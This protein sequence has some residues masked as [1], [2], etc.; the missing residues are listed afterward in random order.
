MPGAHIIFPKR[1]QY[2]SGQRYCLERPSF[3][4]GASNTSFLPGAHIIMAR[5]AHHYGQVRTSF[6]PGA[7]IIMARCAQHC[8]HVRASL[9]PD[10]HIIMAMCAH[11]YGQVRT[12]LWPGAHIIMARCAH[13]CGQ[14]GRVICFF[15]RGDVGCSNGRFGQ[16]LGAAMCSLK[17]MMCGL[18]YAQKCTKK[19]PIGSRFYPLLK[20]RG[21]AISDRLV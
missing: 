10:A 11:H 2:S 6:L 17:T 12:L 5:C 9:W 15:Q 16:S 21:L 18:Q 20:N 1:V 3:L 14:V 7:R 19:A 4:P 13:H 8:D